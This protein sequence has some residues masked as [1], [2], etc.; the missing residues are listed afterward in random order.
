ACPA[1]SSAWPPIGLAAELSAIAGRSSAPS[2]SAWCSSWN[3]ASAVARPRLTRLACPSSAP[4]ARLSPACATHTVWR[5]LLGRRPSLLVAAARASSQPG[6]RAARGSRRL[7]CGPDA[8]P[9]GI[10]CSPVRRARGAPLAR[11]LLRRL[12]DAEL[13]GVARSSGG[14]SASL[15]RRN[16]HVAQAGPAGGPVRDDDA[17]RLPEQQPLRALLLTYGCSGRGQLG[18]V[19]L[20]AVASE[21]SFGR[22]WKGFQVSMYTLNCG[23][24]VMEFVGKRRASPG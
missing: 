14:S 13:P 11:V 1:A 3:L 4:S 18:I 12:R 8:C 16:R 20:E 7:R 2:A 21:L 10:L 24:A 22:S 19:R 15:V 5:R 9:A 17:G 23:V 6:H